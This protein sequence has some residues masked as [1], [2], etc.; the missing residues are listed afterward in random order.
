MSAGVLAM[1]RDDAGEPAIAVVIPCYRAANT[2]A[3]VLADIGPEVRDIWCIDDGSPDDTSAVVVKAAAAD[4]R[5]HLLKRAANGGVGAAV[6]DGYRAAIAAGAT[7]IVKVDSDGQMDPAFIGEFAAPILSGQADYVKGN[8][9]FNADTVSAM[10]ASRLIGNAGLSFFSKLSTGYWDLFDPTNGYTAIHADVA[11]ALP[12]DRLH[13]RFFFESDLLFRLS[14]IHAR[15]IELPLSAQYDAPNSHL[16]ELRCLFT[17]PGLHLQNAWKRIV[18]NYFLRNFSIASVNLLLGVAL[19]MFGLAFGIAHWVESAETDVPATTGT[20]MLSAVPFL[21]GMQLLLSFLSQDMA[22][23]PR[24]AI[25]PFI[26]R[27]RVLVR[28]PED[29]SQ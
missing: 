4:P 5:I 13:Y 15:V 6:V 11:A 2:L 16:S 25:H 8:R 20:V 19:V 27:R 18:Y 17:F 22:Q 3:A 9:F 26:A 29:A 28:I 7:V 21:L 24:E 12:L 1:H 10:P 14:I 23:V